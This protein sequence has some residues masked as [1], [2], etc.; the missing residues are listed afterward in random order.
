MPSFATLHTRRGGQSLIRLLALLLALAM[1]APVLLAEDWDHDRDRDHEPGKANDL[2]G[3]WLQQFNP[4][5]LPLLTFNFGGTASF[6]IQ[7]DVLFTPVQTPEHGLW[8]R[9]GARTFIAT[10]LDIEYNRDAEQ[11]LYATVKVEFDIKLYPSGDQYDA[12]IFAQETLTNGQVINYGPISA[13]G[14]RL[15]LTP[16]PQ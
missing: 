13:H 15:V 9:T 16:P 6:D 14:T 10:F 11:S 2:T 1:T 4:G 7:G 5:H 8:K 12:T 3:V